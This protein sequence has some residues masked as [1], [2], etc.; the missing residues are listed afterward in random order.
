MSKA[1]LLLIVV[2]FV[3][4]LLALIWL[5]TSS[6]IDTKQDQTRA[7]VEFVS[8]IANANLESIRSLSVKVAGSIND[9]FAASEL[10]KPNA[11]I[12]SWGEKLALKCVDEKCSQI[13]VLSK[14]P[15]RLN[16]NGDLDDIVSKDKRRK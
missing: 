11:L 8:E 16:D 13:I 7:Q 14:G 12:D 5:L 3:F 15:N 6:Q 10:L 4:S 2:T 1:K 9:G